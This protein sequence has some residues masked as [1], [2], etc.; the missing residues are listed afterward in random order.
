MAPDTGQAQGIYAHA[1]SF[2]KKPATLNQWVS[3]INKPDGHSA[4]QEDLGDAMARAIRRL[5]W[6]PTSSRWLDQGM[7]SSQYSPGLI[8]VTTAAICSAASLMRGQLVVESTR[9][10]REWG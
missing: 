1:S 6:L 4:C 2:I 10:A 3:E 8:P 9:T 5:R 7:R